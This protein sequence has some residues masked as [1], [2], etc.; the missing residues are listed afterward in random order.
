LILGLAELVGIRSL[1][2]SNDFGYPKNNRFLEAGKRLLSTYFN[3]TLA[4]QGKEPMERLQKEGKSSWYWGAAL[5]G[6]GLAA[7][8]VIRIGE[9]L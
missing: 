8:E 9:S 1:P 5:L 4:I 6:V 2:N 3:W 7:Y